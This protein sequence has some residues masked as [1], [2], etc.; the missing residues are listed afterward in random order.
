MS[1]LLGHLKQRISN[2]GAMT[3]AEYMAECLANPEHGYYIHNEPFGVSGDF[4]TAPEISQMFG[5]LLGLWAV[6][7]WYAMGKPKSFNLIELGPGRGTLM[8]DAL[9]AAGGLSEFMAGLNLHLIETSQRLRG[10]QKQALAPFSPTWHDDISSLPDGPFILIANEFFDAL[11]VH[12]FE[13]TEHGWLERRVGVADDQFVFTP[14]PSSFSIEADVSSAGQ[15]RVGD[16]F[17]ASPESRKITSE[18]AARCKSQ[19]GCALFI[20]YGHSRSG[21]GDT[22]QAVKAH[23]YADVLKTPG[24]AD[25][26]AHVDF[27]ALAK[28]A[29]RAGAIAYGSELQGRFLKMLGINERTEVLSA[30]ATP[31]QLA[32]LRGGRDRLINDDQMGSLF[33]VLAIASPDLPPPSGFQVNA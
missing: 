19:S 16:I 3:V 30:R 26:T 23:A 11:P 1:G 28:A 22:L 25:L 5:E 6:H 9:R 12:Q 27:E 24:D 15:P 31:D 2:D 7:Q 18:L 8:S 13:Y 33:K 4:V 14:W 17:E 29:A 21:Y 10:F 32:Q 20:D